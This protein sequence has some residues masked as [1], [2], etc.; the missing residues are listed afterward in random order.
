M[1]NRKYLRTLLI[2]DGPAALIDGLFAALHARGYKTVM[3][4][5][6]AETLRCVKSDTAEVV[7]TGFQ[8]AGIDSC[9]VLDEVKNTCRAYKIIII[10]PDPDR[11]YWFLQRGA[12]E[13]FDQPKRLDTLLEQLVVLIEDRRR[14]R[15]FAI[16]GKVFCKITDT[17]ANQRYEG[18]LVNVS[19]DGALVKVPEKLVLKKAHLEFT[20]SPQ[21]KIVC[22]ASA[23]LVRTT[24]HGD[25]YLMGF[26][27]DDQR[28]VDLLKPLVPYLSLQRS[29]K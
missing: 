28:E 18:L 21:E 8:I 2:V 17:K 7:V 26:Y 1:K 5:D 6:G 9:Q 19:L 24:K 22:R 23:S 29:R 16:K 3:T 10:S 11:R 14:T 12:L 15:R 13:V 4:F 27:F 20:L 25:D